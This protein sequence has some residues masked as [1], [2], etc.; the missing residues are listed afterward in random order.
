MP[1]LA[2]TLR[3]ME[4]TC[5]RLCHDLGGLIGTIGGAIDLLAD[6]APEGDEILAFART[7]SKT[8]TQRVRL[9]RAAW[10]PDAG[11]MSWPALRDLA[12]P[13][14]T[15]RRVDL[16]FAMRPPGIVFPAVAARL[17]LNLI[18]LAGEGLPKGG[19]V[20]L[21][22]ALDDIFVVI[23]GPNAVWT[24]GL[25]ACAQDPKAA[26]AALEDARS[27]QMPLTVL[28]ALLSDYRLSPVLGPLP[29]GGSGIVAV[30]LSQK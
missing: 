29:R 20:T 4:Q 9:M 3:L 21:T 27:V 14:M 19:T 2:D 13:A 8:L 17:L 24:S 23:D 5:A 28:L 18:L 1:D 6:D 30:R 10:G 12:E 22:G 11:P 25:A 26:V 7:A 16:H 15:A